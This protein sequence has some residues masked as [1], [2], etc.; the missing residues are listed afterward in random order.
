[1]QMQIS[2]GTVSIRN[3]ENIEKFSCVDIDLFNH[4]R[5]LDWE[6][7]RLREA[8]EELHNFRELS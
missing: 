8:I 5:N 3:G 1:M 6:K 7:S 2:L 4:K